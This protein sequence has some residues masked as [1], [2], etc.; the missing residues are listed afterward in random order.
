MFQTGVVLAAINVKFPVKYDLPGFLNQ[1]MHIFSYFFL[2]NN[3][4]SCWNP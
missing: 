2:F 1:A 4:I 3:L